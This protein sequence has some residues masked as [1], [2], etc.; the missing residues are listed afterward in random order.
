[1]AEVLQ[2]TLAGL[3]VSVAVGYVLLRLWRLVR[4]DSP[5]HCGGCSGCHVSDQGGQAPDRESP[6]VN[7]VN[8][9]EF[10]Q[11]AN[12]RRGSSGH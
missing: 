7:I 4:G 1:M 10:E 9:R 6:Y 8:P 3:I 2:N 12:S 11:P 5:G